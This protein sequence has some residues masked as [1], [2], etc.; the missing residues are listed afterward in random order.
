MA[1]FVCISKKLANA[2]SI[3]L[4]IL[5]RQDNMYTF[6]WNKLVSSI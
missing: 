3:L 6:L 4:D 1:Y 2:Q 5:V